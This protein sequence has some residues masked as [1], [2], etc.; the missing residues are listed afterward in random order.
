A[1]LAAPDAALVRSV[2]ADGRLVAD[3]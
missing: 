1:A 2:L 3:A